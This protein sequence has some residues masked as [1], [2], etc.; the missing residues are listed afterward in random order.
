MLFRLILALCLLV[1]GPVMAERRVALI[2]GNSD[3]GHAT[4][5]PN[6]VNDATKIAEKLETLGYDV[7]LR[8]NLSGQ[9]FRVALG[10]FTESALGADVA[11]VYYAGHGIELSGRNY[12]IPT[13]SEMRSEMTAQ[14][15]TIDLDQVMTAV[16][17]AKSLGIV[18]LDACRDNPF[19]R[20]MQRRDASRAVSRGLAPVPL[21]QQSSILVSFAAEAGRTAEDGNGANSP[22][23]EAFL[24]LLGGPQMEVGRM[25][26]ALRSKV[27]EKTNGKQTP[28]EEARLPDFDVYL[29]ATAPVPPAEPAVTKPEP[30]P[31][32]APAVSPTALFYEAARTNDRT[33][34]TNFIAQ[35][36]N[37]ERAGD[38]RKLLDAIE[39]DLMWSQVSKEATE[40]ALRRY[41]LIFPTG[42]H[43]AE[44][45]EKIAAL[46]APPPPVAPPAPT[47]S[48]ADLGSCPTLGGAGSVSLVA[49]NDTLFVRTGPG[50]GYRQIGELPYNAQG[51]EI[52][53]CS[54][55][56]CT[57]SYG[58]LAGFASQKFLTAGTSQQPPSAFAGVYGLTGV[59]AA[60]R[61]SVRAGPGEKYNSVATLIGSATDIEVVDCQAK[62]GAAFRWCFISWNQV[63][64]WID[65]KVLIDEAGR[66]A[67]LGPRG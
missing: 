18:M 45:T 19:A 23:A 54:N 35:F 33:L 57:L 5:L 42:L 66:L 67:S 12:L 29:T 24:E 10:E 36:P 26:R 3:Y 22:Y 61:V 30:P 7:L 40:V 65:G 34:L 11:L 17:G 63:S 41:L 56:W 8:T 48:A 27:R 58:C 13:D 60:T 4:A 46:T 9:E 28:V 14:F 47:Y 53:S 62:S 21:D 50:T 51:I 32:T 64:G 16:R 59:S 6:P 1:A 52:K 38:A 31:A 39:D 43:A 44:A 2:I 20:S 37:H 15:E 49:S 55:K 25:F